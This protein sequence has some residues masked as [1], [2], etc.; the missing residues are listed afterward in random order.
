[1]A[2]KTYDCD[3]CGRRHPNDTV[4]RDDWDS[5]VAE[6]DSLQRQ[7]AQALGI[8][9]HVP[10]AKRSNA[11]VGQRLLQDRVALA[12]KLRVLGSENHAHAI[13]KRLG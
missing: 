9:R 12:A 11:V 3:T 5:L 1:M 10:P 4:C 8:R 7:L 2:R 6:R 13:G